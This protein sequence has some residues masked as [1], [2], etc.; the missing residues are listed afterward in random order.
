MLVEAGGGRARA[1]NLISPRGR[2]VGFALVD[3][4]DREALAFCF[5]LVARA[6]TSMSTT[7]LGTF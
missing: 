4:Q 2:G 1:R 6:Q 3:D 5:A 7:L